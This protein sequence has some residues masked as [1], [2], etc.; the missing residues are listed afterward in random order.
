MSKYIAIIHNATNESIM[1][2]RWV[3]VYYQ[4]VVVAV[5]VAVV[6]FVAVIEVLSHTLHCFEGVRI[7]FMNRPWAIQVL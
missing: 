2:D 1:N 3:W 7:V 4:V 5:A 6:V